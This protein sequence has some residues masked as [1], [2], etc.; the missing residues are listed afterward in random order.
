M[1][2]TLEPIEAS[3]ATPQTAVQYV[4]S[5]GGGKAEG[6]GKMK[7]VLGGKGAGLAEMTNAGLPVPPGFTIQTE[8]C[9]EYMKGKLS[10]D[11]D[12]QMD[13]ALARLEQTMGQ[14]LGDST[15]PLLVSVRSGAKF[16]MPGMMDTILNLGLNDQSVESLAKRSNNPRF[17]YDSYRRLIQ[18]FGNV[19]LDIE[20]SAFDEVF[21][22]IKK[23]KKAKL[24][25]D[26][27]AK[28][29]QEVIAEYKKVVKKHAKRDFPQEPHEQLVMARDAVF[30]SW[31]NDRAKHY[32]RMNN[33]DDMLGTAVNVQAMVFGNLGETSGTGVGFTRNP[34]TGLK[35]FYGEFLMNAQGE[36]VVSG[37][38][39]PMH[40]TELER[41]NAGAYNELRE[42]TSRREKHYRD[43]QDFEFTVQE[44]KLYMLQTRNG[45]RTGLAAVKIAID[46]VKEGLITKEEGF[47]RVE[48]NQLYDFLVP[49]LDEK[50]TKIEVLTTGLPAS[51]GA[52]VGQIVFSAEE[53]VKKAG[54]GAKKNVIL[55]RGE[56]T[57]ED[58]H[59]MEVASGILTSRG[60]MTSHA[61]VVTRGMGKCCVAGAG[62]IQVSEK[63]REMKVKG[64]T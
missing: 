29:L 51:P 11:V 28:A 43:M 63:A 22:S 48:P 4:Y 5:F 57:P 54:H 56:T 44:G 20:K 13:E 12:K 62:D 23:K 1:S 52:A 10:S 61:A 60:G 50:S 26:L 49:R 36:D 27:D 31:Q 59:G 32:R 24:D 18:M 64:Q 6:N 40:I 16:S 55:V 3:M 34:A 8:A 30:R 35:E 37:V 46:M 9:R 7:D 2:T 47:M 38:R 14:K 21:E 19:V 25:T 15:N 53:A 41:I 45:K 17:A 58:I 33:I 42:I 39:T